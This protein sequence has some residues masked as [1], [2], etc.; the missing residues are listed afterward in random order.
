MPGERILIFAN[1][2]A[3]RGRGLAIARSLSTHLAAAGY[4]ADTF[5][6]RPDQLP[7]TILMPAARAAIVIGG[8]G[9]LRAAA[10]WLASLRDQG[11]GDIPPL[12][13]V[14]LG[15]ANLMG[16]HLG[17]SWRKR[18]LA[19]QVAAAIER[20]QVRQVDAA[21]ANGRLFLL[22][23]GVGFDAHIV[24]ELDRIRTGPITYASYVMPTIGALASYRYH[25]LRVI[26]DGVEVFTLG[27]AIAFVGNVPEYGT[28]FPM[29]P[30]A[31]SDDGLLD[32]CVLPCR[33]PVDVVKLFALAAAG[34]HPDAE[35]VVY[36]K[37]RHVVIES[38]EVVRVQLDGDAAGTTP[39]QIDLL[40][41]SLPF[42]VAPPLLS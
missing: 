24:H 28:G 12:L 1:P 39:L 31:R 42:I 13:V 38:P 8:D 6:D 5:T 16:R 3:G 4:V 2:I 11:A 36:L 30:L 27:P 18:T 29:L 14:P 21:R 15:T 33:N 26:A 7:P 19:P 40:P 22:M 10:E 23:A 25:A 17:L 32:V 9:T 41:F 20:L 37:A 35:G 34:A